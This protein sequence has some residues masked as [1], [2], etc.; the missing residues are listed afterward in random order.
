M[1]TTIVRPWMFVWH[2]LPLNVD[3]LIHERPE[4]CFPSFA[5][6]PLSERPSS[7]HCCRDSVWQDAFT[8]WSTRWRPSVTPEHAWG[9]WPTTA[10]CW[11]RRDATSTSCWTRS[12]SPRRSTSSMSEW[13]EPRGNPPPGWGGS[14]ACLSL[15]G[16]GLQRRWNHGGRQRAA[17]D[18]T[19]VSFRLWG[20]PKR[21]VD[22]Q[23]VSE[24]HLYLYRARNHTWE[25]YWCWFST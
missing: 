15:Q 19:E 7:R 6:S 18:R 9:F 22:V 4:A 12:S 21:S 24:T 14:L 25:R 8:R 16:L 17:A 11:R 23:H 13:T 2:F 3:N 20:R 10:C 5:K 1:K